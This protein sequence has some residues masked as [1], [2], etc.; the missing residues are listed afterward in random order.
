[1]SAKCCKVLCSAVSGA[2]TDDVPKSFREIAEVTLADITF[3]RRR[4]DEVDGM[5]TSVL[6]KTGYAISWN[7][8]AAFLSALQNLQVSVVQLLEQADKGVFTNLREA[9]LRH[10]YPPQNIYNA[11][12]MALATI[13][14]PEKIIAGRGT[15]QVKAIL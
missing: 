10:D 7:K 13:Q 5:K 2:S 14:K 12:E 1:M 6:G 9:R 4:Q 11:D 8:V 3:N 15:K